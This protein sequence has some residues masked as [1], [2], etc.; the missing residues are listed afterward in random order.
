MEPMSEAL[1]ILVADFQLYNTTN[2][3]GGEESNT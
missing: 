1:D 3:T 2:S